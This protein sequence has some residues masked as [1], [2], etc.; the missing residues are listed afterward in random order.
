[1]YAIAIIWRG[2][3][4]I[5][6]VVGRFNT[7]VIFSIFYIAIL[8]P[9]ALVHKAGHFFTFQKTETSFP[10]YWQKKER[11]TH[12]ASRLSRQF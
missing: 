10:S 3:K 8:G 4:T 9:A 7:L 6:F 11:V 5:L 12:D 1:M 2:V